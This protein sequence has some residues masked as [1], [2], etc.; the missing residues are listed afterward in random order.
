VRKYRSRLRHR[1][2]DRSRSPP[3]PEPVCGRQTTIARSL[4]RQPDPRKVI[5]GSGSQRREGRTRGDDPRVGAGHDR[6]HPA[7]RR[8]RSIGLA[9]RKGV[10][11]E[12]QEGFI[13]GAEPRE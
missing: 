8:T 4:D 2:V 13:F 1:P 7:A 3:R 5:G 11:P 9:R 12:G 10:R 6:A